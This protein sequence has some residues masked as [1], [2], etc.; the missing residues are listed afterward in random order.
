ES[1]LLS[2]V[3]WLTML[4]MKLSLRITGLI[5]F[6]SLVSSPNRRQIDSKASLTAAGGLAMVLTSTRCCFFIELTD[7][8]GNGE[9]NLVLTE[10]QSLVEYN[11]ITVLKANTAFE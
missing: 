1:N 7:A 5:F 11:N 3:E 9:R 2:S 6:H 4:L 10:M 8:T